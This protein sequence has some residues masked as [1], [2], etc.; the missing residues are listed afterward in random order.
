MEAPT[1]I[2]ELARI[3]CEVRVPQVANVVF[4]GKTPD[5]G[6]EAFRKMGFSIVLYAN[7]ALQAALR[8]AYD[9]LRAL[10]SDGSLASVADRLASF[11][12]RQNAVAKG[13][14]DALE[15]RYTSLRRE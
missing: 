14:W 4:G 15:A 10:K 1:A 11:E 6:R 5:P 8:A 12:E 9:V 13:A 2:D 7:A 3:A